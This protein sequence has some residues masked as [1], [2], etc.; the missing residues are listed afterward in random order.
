MAKRPTDWFSD[1]LGAY[2]LPVPEREYVF[3]EGRKWR[4]DYAWPSMR[5]AVEIDGGGFRGAHQQV[6][7]RGADELKRNWAIASGWR[8]F[9]FNTWHF[10]SDERRREVGAFLESV[11]IYGEPPCG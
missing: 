10:G 1:I 9:S 4:F 5:V 8:V 7:R 6:A 3:F 11:L 2:R